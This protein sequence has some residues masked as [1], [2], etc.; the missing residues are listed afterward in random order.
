MGS[1]RWSIASLTDG[2]TQKSPPAGRDRPQ[3][4]LFRSSGAAEERNHCLRHCR[5][6][7][8]VVVSQ[9]RKDR[10]AMPGHAGAVPAG[11]ALA[12]TEKTE[13]HDGVR[14]GQPIRVTGHD[15]HGH[16]QTW[17]LVAPVV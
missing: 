2:T 10:Q 15:H 11:V 12:A 3:P 9:T 8:D 4:P 7:V 13:E 6:E 14:R 17:H 1:Y 5:A 16:R